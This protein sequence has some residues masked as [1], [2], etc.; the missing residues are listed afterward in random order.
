MLHSHRSAEPS[1]PHVSKRTVGSL[2]SARILGAATAI[3]EGTIAQS[4]SA[5]MVQALGITQRFHR[6][7]PGLYRKSGVERRASV[8]LGPPHDDLH[9]RQ[10]FYVTATEQDPSGPTTAQRM[11]A[12]ETF[13]GPL[14]ARAVEAALHNSHIE[15]N[16]ISH[17]ITVS[18][19][20]F[21]SPGID[22]FLMD[23]F[24]LSE[25][26]QRTHIGFMG[27]H[28]MLNGLRM[29]DAIAR[30]D[31]NARV[32]V[33][34]VELC[35]L[36][37]QYCEDSEQLVANALFADGAAAAILGSPASTA[38]SSDA[39]SDA[40]EPLPSSTWRIVST[41]SQR[42]PNTDQLMSWRIGNHG[43]QMT[44]SPKVPA[45]IEAELEAAING[46]LAPLGLTT[47]DIHHWAIHPGGPRILDSVGQA[48]GLAESQLQPSR[49]VLA[50]YGN[51]S[52]PTVMFIL[53]SISQENLE[54]P[55]C[56]M[57]GFGPGLHMEAILLH[58]EP[59]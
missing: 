17:L 23:R 48:L 37:Q 22:H 34:A 49:D 16:Q 20:G 57:L 28:G 54:H 5:L 24:G 1:A 40:I 39:H 52:S 43:F 4:D 10:S 29:A 27:C 51:M 9:Q 18:C 6:L 45:V 7:L 26:L 19:T 36:H 38:E 3:P 58:R 44:L 25:Q 56:V 8:L 55:W 30:A 53:E 15:A 31:A 35:S 46:W 14:L 59:I 50:R 2:P 33:G 41:F 42:I 12:Y 21:C 13:A 11:Q 32:L 47:D